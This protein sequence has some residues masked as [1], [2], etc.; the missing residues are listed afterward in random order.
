MVVLV[1]LVVVASKLLVS[2]QVFPRE[3]CFLR[4]SAAQSESKDR[5]GRFHD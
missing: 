1:V 5:K 2:M 3:E 4:G